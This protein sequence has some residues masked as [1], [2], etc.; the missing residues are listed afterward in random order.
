M[1]TLGAIRLIDLV[2][3]IG[4]EVIWL[5]EFCKVLIG[6]PYSVIDLYFF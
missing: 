6:R 1:L 3:V 2:E 5:D 4:V